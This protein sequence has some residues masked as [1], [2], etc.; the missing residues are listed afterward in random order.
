MPVSK[1]RKR[2]GKSVSYDKSRQSRQSIQRQKAMQLA[3]FN[4][5]KVEVRRESMKALSEGKLCPFAEQ[6]RELGTAFKAGDKVVN[7]LLG[8]RTVV[9]MEKTK[10]EIRYAWVS[11]KEAGV[12]SE[13][14]LI[15]YGE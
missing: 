3:T 1:K 4:I 9:D 11:I 5:R 2:A 15:A 8:T 14:E 13:K 7:K 6:Q 12:C 10:D